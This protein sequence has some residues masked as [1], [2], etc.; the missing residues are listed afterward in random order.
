MSVSALP[1]KF[2]A[3]GRIPRGGS[4]VRCDAHPRV[5]DTRRI[6]PASSLGATGNEAMFA[7]VRK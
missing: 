3:P 7:T 5:G 6:A 4:A 2:P 1:S